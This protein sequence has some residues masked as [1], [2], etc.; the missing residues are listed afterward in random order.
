MKEIIEALIRFE[1]KYDITPSI[2]FDHEIG[3]E[4]VYIRLRRKRKCIEKAFYFVPI[5]KDSE[6]SFEIYNPGFEVEIEKMIEELLSATEG[7]NNV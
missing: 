4:Y 7:K 5:G 2:R 6:E 1:S 3:T